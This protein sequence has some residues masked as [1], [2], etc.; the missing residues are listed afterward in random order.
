MRKSRIEKKKKRRLFLRNI[1]L[2]FLII[3]P[4][5]AIISS[6]AIYYAV[7]RDKNV[8]AAAA[9][10]IPKDQA[11]KAFKYNF[12]MSAR[13]L[14]RV[15]IKKFEKYEDA[16]SQIQLLKKKKL[17]GFIVKEQG[18]LVAYGL[19]INKSQAETA[20]KY[21]KRK[22]FESIV[23]VFNINGINIKYNDIDNNLI[24]I[25]SAVDAVA[26]KVLNEKAA[27]CLES[28]Y[29]GKEI[30]E[31]SLEAVIEQETKL[32]KYLNYLKIVKTTENADYKKNLES[33][34]NELLVDKLVVDGS[35]DYYDLQNS[36]MNQGEALRKFYEN[37][38]V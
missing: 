36:L 20:A 4:V 9:A 14:F 10:F 33:L 7:M 28:L 5:A 38:M 35:Y 24:D 12:D 1:L 34:I 11:V 3:I 8:D 6:F 21:L 13:Q 22:G 15:E 2:I 29:S 18:Y 17:N 27:L 16:E 23:N 32:V 31:K 25:A 37:L 30:N 26:I 19:F